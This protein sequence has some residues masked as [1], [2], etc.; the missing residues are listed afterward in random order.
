MAGDD[1]RFE[2]KI[3]GIRTAEAL[4]AA[5]YVAAVGEGGHGHAT[6]RQRALQR[7]LHGGVVFDQK[8]L[9]GPIRTVWRGLQGSG[10]T[11]NP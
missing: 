8:Q 11:R 1:R 3:C 6:A 7:G 5:D 9:H 2:I 10:C 4:D